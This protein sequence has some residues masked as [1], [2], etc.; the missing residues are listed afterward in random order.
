MLPLLLTMVS[1]G[2]A[3]GVCVMMLIGSMI[4]DVVEASE[5][6]SAKREE[7]QF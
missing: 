6:R 7:G 1:L 5:E 3:F 4:A 2:T